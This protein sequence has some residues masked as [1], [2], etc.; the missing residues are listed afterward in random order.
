MSSNGAPTPPPPRDLLETAHRD[1][2]LT[3]GHILGHVELL[4]ELAEDHN[5]ETFLTELQKVYSETKGIVD[6]VH[7]VLHDPATALEDVDF[8][9]L[10]FEVRTALNHSIGYLEMLQEKACETD[11]QLLVPDLDNA[12]ILCRQLVTQMEAAAQ[13]AGAGSGPTSANE[14]ATEGL[15]LSEA[16]AGATTTPAH[17]ESHAG[18]AAPMHAPVHASYIPTLLVVDDNIQSRD[19]LAKQLR[20]LGFRVVPA[21]SGPSAME[22][23]QS[24]NF[25]LVLLDVVMPGMSGYDV[26]QWIKADAHL[27]HTPVLMIA[28][29]NDTENVVHCVVIGAD[30]YITKPT[31]PVLLKVRVNACLEKA[32]WQLLEKA[33]L[34]QIEEARAQSERVLINM[35][36]QSIIAPP[37]QGFV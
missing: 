22:R 6:L 9:R 2:T 15:Q 26:L 16:G 30:D 27:R 33:Y 8:P 14:A 3:L 20:G 10:R 4:Q 28:A 7:E 25:D 29:T 19:T 11:Q 18:A 23:L 37:P 32:R 1:L 36:P 35:L 13:A 17:A 24:E 21:G 34:R 12:H 5:Q 31:D